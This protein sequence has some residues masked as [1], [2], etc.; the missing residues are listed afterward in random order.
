MVN[1]NKEC[2]TRRS[3]CKRM[4][5]VAITGAFAGLEGAATPN[6]PLSGQA[7]VETDYSAAARNAGRLVAVCGTYCG[8]CPMYINNQPINEKARKEMFGIHSG[9]CLLP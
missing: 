2:T 3:F 9:I 8:A 5:G 1:A 7:G 4:A 6:P